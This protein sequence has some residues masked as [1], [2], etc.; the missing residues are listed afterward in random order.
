MVDGGFWS[1]DTWTLAFS[2]TKL[3][4]SYINL[5]TPLNLCEICEYFCLKE[6]FNRIG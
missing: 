6:C 5:F 2:D 3:K 1:Q 4:K